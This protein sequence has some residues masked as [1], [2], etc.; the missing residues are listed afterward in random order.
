[1]EEQITQPTPKQTEPKQSSEDREIE[2]LSR[3][4][5]DK[6]IAF[7]KQREIERLKIQS[8]KL[9]MQSRDMQ[10]RFNPRFKFTKEKA[11]FWSIATVIAIAV[12]IILVKIV[13]KLF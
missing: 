12:A 7:D 5:E 4:N 8:N 1:M 9:D 2:R 3:E 11:K 10:K 13:Q 6:Q